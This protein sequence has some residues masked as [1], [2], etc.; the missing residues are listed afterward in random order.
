MMLRRGAAALSALALAV[1]LSAPATASGPSGMAVNPAVIDPL[2]SALAA[3]PTPYTP[4]T[5]T[6]CPRGENACIDQVI[7][8][9]QTRLRPLANSCSDNAVFGLA[10]LR[11]TENVR[12]ANRH[13][14]FKD[15]LWL[16]RLDALFA[17]M[18]FT[19][20]DTYAKG[21]S[22][23]PA[24]RV[25]L[26][27]TK[28]QKLTG[29]GD[30][31]INMNAHINNDFP[32]ALVADGLTAKNGASHKVDHNA[33]NDRLDSLYGPVFNEE[34]RRFDPSFNDYYAGGLTGTVAGLIMRGWRE[35]VW[36]NAEALAN[37]KTPQQKALVEQ[38]ISAY[39]LAQA[40]LIE[41]IPIFQATPASNAKRNAWCAAHHG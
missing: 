26:D 37:A 13:G 25:A 12:D 2:I 32:R 17:H 19:T 6:I 4:Y 3:L 31:M 36:R 30:F 28:S 35:M 18:Y 14:W 27:D 23:P 1:G 7:R 41:A 34:M 38:W 20:M 21:G 9:M 15:R 22:V 24:W 10:Y 39:A 33:Y 29:L 40:K 16:N 8:T 5:G 11:V